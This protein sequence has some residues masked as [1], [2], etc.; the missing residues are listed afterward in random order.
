[1]EDREII[2]LFFARAENAISKLSDKYGS[3]CFRVANNILNNRQDA[4]EC[5][6]DAYL[7][8]W[9][10]IPPQRPDPFVSYVCRIV[11][12]LSLAKYHA[13]TAKKRNNH[14]DVA[15]EELED[16]FPSPDTVEEEFQAG[17]TAEI[18]GRF[19]RS[20]GQEQRVMFVRRYYYADS[21]SEIAELFG[22]S[23][24]RVSVTLARIRE[25]LKKL[26]R[27][28]GVTL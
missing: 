12:N 6:N 2:E 8:V 23:P 13:N 9:N 20:L 3:L 24:H 21:L 18:I 28:E 14:Y 26:L 4:E 11:R 22:V 25:K 16:C 17:A 27:K 10:S 5:V 19:L 7:G 15:L 1:M